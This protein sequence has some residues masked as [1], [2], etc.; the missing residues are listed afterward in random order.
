MRIHTHT[1]FLREG[2]SVQI[3][4]QLLS[5]Q[6]TSYF[7]HYGKKF[8]WRVMLQRSHKMW[9]LVVNIC[10]HFLISQAILTPPSMIDDLCIHL[11]GTTHILYKDSQIHLFTHILTK[12]QSLS[13]LF[14][15]K[16]I[17]II[18]LYIYT[19]FKMQIILFTKFKIWENS[20]SIMSSKESMTLRQAIPPS[21]TFSDDVMLQ[22]T[23]R[24]IT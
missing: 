22:Y 5:F 4:F 8:G 12:L 16:K 9:M 24:Y 17:I 3:I 20:I 18:T 23:Y 15:K 14:K 6:A 21:V 2:L 19:Q 13:F 11:T 1:G 7:I 10:K